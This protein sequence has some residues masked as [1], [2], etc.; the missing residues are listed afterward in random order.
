[1]CYILW[2][3]CSMLISI[4][5]WQSCIFNEFQHLDG[6]VGNYSTFCLITVVVFYKN[7]ILFSFI[8]PNIKC[9]VIKCCFLLT[10]RS[11]IARHC[12]V[13]KFYV[14]KLSK[15]YIWNQYNFECHK[16]LNQQ[17]PL[18]KHLTHRLF[19][20]FLDDVHCICKTNLHEILVF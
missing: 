5:S 18:W 19:T 14:Y 4:C 11:V 9:V 12:V 17:I 1:M 8:L 2:C 10:S 20:H 13:S 7:S 15:L 6:M 3:N 16:L